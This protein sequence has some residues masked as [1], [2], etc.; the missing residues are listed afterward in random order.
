MTSK[1]PPSLYVIMHN[2][3][4]PEGQGYG[5]HTSVMPLNYSES[6]KPDAVRCNLAFQSEQAAWRWLGVAPRDDS[7]HARA[8]RAH[9]CVRPVHPQPA[10]ALDPHAMVRA[11]MDFDKICHQRDALLIAAEQLTIIAQRVRKEVPT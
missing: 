10:N 8:V 11:V 2:T 7:D 1:L 6:L 5:A 9:W 4:D 3:D